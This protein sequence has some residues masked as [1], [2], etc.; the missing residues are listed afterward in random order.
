M[1]H[2]SA[3]PMRQTDAPPRAAHPAPTAPRLVAPEAAT[4]LLALTRQRLR[5]HNQLI[6]LIAACDDAGAAVAEGRQERALGGPCLALE[7]LEA[8]LCAR[9]AAISA[10]RSQLDQ[11]G[12]VEQRGYGAR[13]ESHGTGDA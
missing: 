9:R 2:A 13:E 11:L 3:A 6:D 10:M 4:P 8:R 5:L 1:I 12:H 7:A